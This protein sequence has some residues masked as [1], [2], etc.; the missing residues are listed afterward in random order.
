VGAKL[1]GGYYA[2]VTNQHANV[3]TIIDPDPNGDNNGTARTNV[4]GTCR[5]WDAEA[6]FGRFS[7]GFNDF[8]FAIPS[9]LA[10][11]T[12]DSFW[13]SDWRRPSTILNYN[14]RLQSTAFLAHEISVNLQMGRL[15]MSARQPVAF[16]P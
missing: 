16:K 4:L 9:A 14:A 5:K 11:L 6:T 7:V 2:Y 15:R 8:R 12:I 3:L 1:G 10:A 13:I